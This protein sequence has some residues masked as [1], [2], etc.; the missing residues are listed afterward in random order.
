MIKQPL[1]SMKVHHVAITVNNLKESVNFY[2][3]IL[4]F[5]IAQKFAR[6]DMGAYA[7][8][9]K[10]NDFQIE[11]WQFRDMKENS[12]SLNNIKVKGIRHIA[13]EV[14]N[15]NETISKLIDKGLKFSEPKLG[16]SGHNYSFTTDPNGVALE[17]YEK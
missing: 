9:V 1:I 4:G 2:T 12:N 13:F 7:T 5:E 6:E 16:A 8:F 15:L 14:E 11:L 17:F 10:L 3:Q